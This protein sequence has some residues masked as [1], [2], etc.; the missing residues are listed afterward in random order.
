[1]KLIAILFIVFG[2]LSLPVGLANG[3]STPTSADIEFLANVVR[4]GESPP[5][6]HNHIHSQLG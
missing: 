3:Q 5:N 6:I 1:M 4:H 2:Y